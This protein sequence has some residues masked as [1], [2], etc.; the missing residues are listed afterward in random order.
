MA[1]PGE[2]PIIDG[3]NIDRGPGGYLVMIYSNYTVFSGFEILS[4]V[5]GGTY[6]S[7]VMALGSYIN[8]NHC[9]VHDVDGGIYISG[10]SYNIAEYNEVYNACMPNS[11]YPGKVGAIN[12]QGM[13]ICHARTDGHNTIRH[14]YIHNVWGEAVSTF[15]ANY[16]TIEDNIIA[17]GWSTNIYVSDASYAT[18]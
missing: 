13:T 7:A 6:N 16:S 15:E 9:K 18:I 10:G 8:I 14:N 3:T 5:N 12:G 11:L 17:D 4:G 1:Y 2:T